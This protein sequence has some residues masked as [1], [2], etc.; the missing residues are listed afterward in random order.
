M[1]K[2]VESTVASLPKELLELP[3]EVLLNIMFHLNDT[4]LLNMTRVCK[5]F[6]SIAKDAFGKKYNGKSSD[7]YF[8]V[9][10]FYENIV[11]ERKQNQS[12]FCSFGEKM[13]AIDLKFDDGPVARDHWIFAVI[14]R[15]CTKL[16][17]VKIRGGHDVDLLKMFHS[18]PISSLTHLKLAD[19]GIA[20]TQWSKYRHPNL[21]RFKA[22][23]LYEHVQIVDFI[24]TNNQLREIQLKHLEVDNFL[25]FIEAIESKCKN[26][27]KLE[28]IESN[29]DI[30]WNSEII[31]ILCKMT[32]LNWLEI[33]AKKLKL[34]QLESLV[35]RLTNL[36]T[37]VLDHISA[38]SEIYENLSRAISICQHVP[39]L[40][41]RAEDVDSSKLSFD[42]LNHIAD[43]IMIANKKIVLVDAKDVIDIVKGEVRRNGTIVHN[44]NAVCS[45]STV[46]LLD[47]ND[48]CLK[49]II[50]YLGPKE[51]CALYD[52][53]KKTREAIKKFYLKRSFS[54]KFTPEELS[55]S[56]MWCLGKHIRF[57]VIRQKYDLTKLVMDQ[58]WRRIN[59]NCIYLKGL[60][61]VSSNAIGDNY[62]FPADC[63]W[64]KLETVFFSA[65]STT[66]AINY[67]TLRSFFCPS[68]RSLGV[69][70]L[71]IDDNIARNMDHGDQFHHLT[72]LRVRKFI[73][74]FNG[75][76]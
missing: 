32:T 59:Q 30:L 72:I 38:S 45:K 54:I 51:H 50:E 53:C 25:S 24:R 22:A 28:M 34:S 56:I 31:S 2:M 52:T 46:N 44:Q 14:K 55:E 39:Y 37:L 4:S 40:T 13:V 1:E 58:L 61:I 33:H 29:E 35:R 74:Y 43:K 20:E 23:D 10:F 62:I 5:R 12:L 75:Y 63:V 76:K 36:S 41:I 16:S 26:I 7:N 65:T 69:N 70:C 68:L 71:E 48:K 27:R 11:A 8:K 73:E 9:K 15:F 6:Q 66:Y 49:K 3:D 47:L 64:P 17:K 42:L 57:M 19:L 67:E 60:A 18:L 21:I